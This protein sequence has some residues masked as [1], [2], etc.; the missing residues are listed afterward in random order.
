MLGAEAKFES[1]NFIDLIAGGVHLP[2]VV[3]GTSIAMGV[4]IVFGL[5][6]RRALMD[7]AD[8]TVPESGIT[9]RSVAE[10]LAEWL[11]GFVAGVLE[12]HGTRRYVPFFG[13]LFMFILTANFLGLIPGMEP[14]TSD[15]DLTFAIAII[16]FVY[17]LYQGFKYR[18]FAACAAPRSA[19]VARVVLRGDRGGRQP[20]P[21][22]FARHPSFRQHV[23]R[24]QGARPVHGT[25]QARHSARFLRAGLNRLYRSGAGLRDPGGL[26]RPDGEPLA[27]R[28]KCGPGGAESP[29]KDSVVNFTYRPGPVRGVEEDRGR[30]K[31]MDLADGR[32]QTRRRRK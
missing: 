15:T 30:K 17:Y 11:D 8:S 14:P 12:G 1:G 18:G 20:V 28:I 27:L 25:H 19:V 2:P 31:A 3:V 32:E 6:A 5:L 4:L 16:C 13:T 29:P 9:L 22:V 24:P 23:R 21:S 26:S 7:A 10:V